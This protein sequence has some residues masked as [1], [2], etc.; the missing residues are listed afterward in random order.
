MKR[1]HIVGI[2]PRTGTTL[3]AECM[4][5]CF[6]ID[7]YEQHEASLNT[8]SYGS[9]IYLT[10][11]PQDIMYMSLRFSLDPRLT[12]IC[13]VRDPRD[14]V[15]SRHG[16]NPKKYYTSLGKYK[17]WSKQVDRYSSNNRFII[18]RF[19]DLISDPNGVQDY[20]MSRIP[21][22]V[23]RKSFS[24]FHINAE[25]SDKSSRALNGFRPID[26]VNLSK[27]R[28]HLPRL[29]EQVSQYGDITT[30]VINYGYEKDD[31][32]I[33]ILGNK[34]NNNEKK[35]GTVTKK[36][37]RFKKFYITHPLSA[38]ISYVSYKMSFDLG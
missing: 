4:R 7:R 19:E 28:N 27:W 26:K 21:Y 9:S 23:K 5:I 15:V 32:W 22:L 6:D 25:V 33:K 3:L 2:S 37:Y 20:I 1:I 38:I 31:R 17:Y 11:N 34:V 12:V 8:L 30:D 36:Y 13:M 29:S 10:K 16:N 24:E 18:I 14:I 35:L